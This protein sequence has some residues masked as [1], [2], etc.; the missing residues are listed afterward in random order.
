MI[1]NW[2][3]VVSEK[4]LWIRFYEAGADRD[5]MEIQ[6]WAELNGLICLDWCDAEWLYENLGIPLPR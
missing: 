3:N 6:D 4:E 5:G 2:K 1:K